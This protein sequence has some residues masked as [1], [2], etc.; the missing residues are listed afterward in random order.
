[1]EGALEAGTQARAGW[2]GGRAQGLWGDHAWEK[3]TE[4]FGSAGFAGGRCHS[5][6]GE[7]GRAPGRGVDLAGRDGILGRALHA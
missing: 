4:G 6:L 2:H 3:C 1:M 5:Q 7:S